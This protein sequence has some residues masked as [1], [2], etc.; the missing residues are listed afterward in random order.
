MESFPANYYV[1]APASPQQQPKRTT[2]TERVRPYICSYRELHQPNP[3]THYNFIIS[4]IIT[5]KEDTL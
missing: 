4:L 1:T 3:T 2:T 5:D